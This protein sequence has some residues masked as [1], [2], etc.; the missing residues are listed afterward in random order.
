MKF[1]ILVPVYNVE[2][3]LR[4]CVESVLS[5]KF[6]DYELILVNDGSTDGSPT[7]CQEYA[8]KDKRIKYYPKDN[9]G[10]LLTRR[11]SIR[12]ARGDYVLFLD[13]DDYWEPG[14]LTRLNNA[15]EESKADMIL[16][17]FKR[18]R[19]D[20]SLIYE[21]KDVF[22]DKTLFKENNK[23]DF[24]RKFVS[25][26]R[27]NTLWSKCVKRI[28]IDNDADYS[29]FKDK[30]GED[31]LQSIALIKNAQSVYY[32]NDVLYN[33][34][35]SETG[36]GRNFKLKYIS[37]YESVREH[38]YYCLLQMKLSRETTYLFLC[39]Y[40]E[41][42]MLFMNSISHLCK[43]YSEFKAVC[44]M[45]EAFDLYQNVIHDVKKMRL[46][47]G[48]K[49][50]YYLFNRRFFFFLYVKTRLSNGIISFLRSIK[51][52]NILTKL[53]YSLIVI[54]SNA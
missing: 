48:A 23:E 32:I 12:K 34:R 30:K 9:E 45:V 6:D 38:V 37:D 17:R 19:D 50:N 44:E 15:I 43:N 29:V 16:F 35:L 36:R 41:G 10:L 14:I 26:S 53:K 13:S 27:L 22:P 7:I 11:Y 2:K 21:D 20:G 49:E 4:Q 24:I 33:Y 31:L 46:I 8:V 1:S 18:I 25:S 5:E 47:K 42:I 54:S 3:Y 28:I 40:I 39:R 52:M 51:V